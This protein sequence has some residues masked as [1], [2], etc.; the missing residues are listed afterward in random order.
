MGI[1]LGIDQS[2]LT[3]RYM[4]QSTTMWKLFLWVCMLFPTYVAAQSQTVAKSIATPE[5]PSIKRLVPIRT[6]DLR[7]TSQIEKADRH[8]GP[9]FP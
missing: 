2:D 7:P 5:L 1:L 8:S 3:N 9:V 4:K 6:N